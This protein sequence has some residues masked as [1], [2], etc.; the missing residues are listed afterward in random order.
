MRKLVVVSRKDGKKFKVYG[1]MGGLAR[2]VQRRRF[3]TTQEANDF[4][5]LLS[6]TDPGV[7][8]GEYF[9]REEQP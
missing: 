2:F 3:F 9:I 7:E 6:K 5:L 4:L 1:L 8:R